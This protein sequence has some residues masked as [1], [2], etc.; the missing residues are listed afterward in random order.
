[1]MEKHLNEQELDKLIQ[2]WADELLAPD[3]DNQIADSLMNF[4][5]DEDTEIDVIGLIDNHIHHLA[6]EEDIA[7]RRKWKIFFSIAAASVVLF[8]L[9]SV[10]L[11]NYDYGTHPDKKMLTAKNQVE[12]SS[13]ILNS[14]KLESIADSCNMILAKV[15][16][17]EKPQIASNTNHKKYHS[18]KA[19]EQI[20]TSTEQSLI[21]TI[22]EIN[23]G[24][25]NMVVNTKESLNLA[26]A[27][28]LT[29]D[30]FSNGNEY[31]NYEL[32]SDEYY[33]PQHSEPMQDVNIIETNLIN[34]LYEIRNLNID[35]NFDNKITEI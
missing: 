10:Y 33:S 24:L 9:A 13:K 15:E 34:A 5:E 7:K 26:N 25:A 4:V 1:M 22:A 11:T 12:V 35:L 23:A 19:K 3:I 27:A 16:N 20:E 6:M 28:L 2:D 21:E 31:D 32:I 18:R 17:I 30:L 14:G 29:V 8:I